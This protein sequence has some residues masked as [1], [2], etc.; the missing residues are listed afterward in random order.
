MKTLPYRHTKIIFTIGPA[1]NNVEILGQLLRKGVD[2]CR[3]NMAHADHDWTREAIGNVREACQQVGRKVALM[4]DVKGPE[5]RTGP[6][7]EPMELEEGECF[8]LFLKQEME[9]VTSGEAR[10]VRINYPS[11][12]EDVSEGDT[13]LV[14]SGLIRMEVESILE[15]RIRCTVRIGGPLGS[16]RHINLPGVHVNLPALTRKD[17]ADVE[18][19]IENGVDFFALSFVRSP[20]DLDILRRFIGE[21]GSKAQVI[22]KIEDASAISNLDDIVKA[23]DG[24]MVARGDLGIEIPYE[25]LPLV[26][27]R[28]VRTCQAMGKPVI[29]ATH[30]L[31]SMVQNPLPTRAEITDIAN[32]VFEQADCVMLSGETTVGKYPVEC[33]EVM[34]R[35]IFSIEAQSERRSNDSLP[36]K[37]P[38]ALMLKSAMILS[39]ELPGCSI[40]VFTRAG[41]L[42]RTLSALRPRKSPIFAFTD[43]EEVFQ[44]LLM[45]W[46]V[47]PFL[48]SFKEDPEATIQEAFA[49]LKSR[50][51]VESRNHM[52]VVSNVL[53][54]SKIIDTIQYRPVP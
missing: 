33:V 7:E 14:D 51:W 2:V 46:G 13:V 44:N 41:H 12:R 9:P 30:M 54:G 42:A 21:R 11:L 25:T 35:I 52:V 24:L 1:T 28:A 17:R 26:Q 38:K 22:A 40:A 47:E 50:G 32:A 39:D 23:S 3:L 10:G 6:L 36:L 43:Q 4:M 53:A 37:S 45:Y 19:G 27:R 18:T 29:V 5:I 15:D 20:D 49:R 31:E 48:M 34:N 16:R 8:D